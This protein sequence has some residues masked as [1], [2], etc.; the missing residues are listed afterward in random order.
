MLQLA[1]PYLH[2]SWLHIYRIHRSIP[3]T[4]LSGNMMLLDYT[5]DG[6][7]DC[8]LLVPRQGEAAY[9]LS[10]GTNHPDATVLFLDGASQTEPIEIQS[11][12]YATYEG[13]LKSL[14]RKER[15]HRTVRVKRD[16]GL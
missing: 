10:I 16:L 13:Y 1:F 2:K 4:R 7:R 14:L 6:K 8:M 3:G 5:Q 9:R 11:D 15:N 12:T